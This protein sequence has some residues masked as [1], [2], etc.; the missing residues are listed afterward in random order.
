MRNERRFQF[1]LLLLLLGGLLLASAAQVPPPTEPKLPMG[2]DWSAYFPAFPGCERHLSPLIDNNQGIVGQTAEYKRHSVKPEKEG[3][4]VLGRP[5]T[6]SYWLDTDECGWVGIA[7]TVPYV[8]PVPVL[9][10]EERKAAEERE[11][12]SRK[13]EKKLR[14]I[15]E[16]L[17]HIYPPA[18]PPRP[19]RI[20]GFEA[21]QI[22]Y[23]PC[24]YIECQGKYFTKFR[25]VLAKD[26]QLTIELLGGFEEAKAIVE[27]IDFDNLISAMNK[28]SASLKN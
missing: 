4:I 15:S 12:R 5:L 7:L 20:K 17:K 23:P 2:A 28:Y 18:P 24:D 1:A 6:G 26:K 16:S 9:T 25:I 22:F 14:N 13:T 21:Y 8:P 3:D 10:K 19:I 27:S 11:R